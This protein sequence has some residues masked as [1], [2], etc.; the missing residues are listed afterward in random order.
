MT[1]TIQKVAKTKGWILLQFYRDKGDSLRKT[2]P[3]FKKNHSIR[4]NLFFSCDTNSSN[5]TELTWLHSS[6]AVKKRPLRGRNEEIFRTIDGLKNLLFGG[7][8]VSNNSPLP[9]LA[10]IEIL[11]YIGGKMAE[12][13]A[14]LNKLQKK[15]KEKNEKLLHFLFLHGDVL[16]SR[17]MSTINSCLSSSG[18]SHN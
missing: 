16:M 9:I 2:W 17:V 6:F 3:S 8:L 14:I 11:A 4:K 5:S 15:N 18:V 7:Y 1:L 12:S 13:V 10:Y